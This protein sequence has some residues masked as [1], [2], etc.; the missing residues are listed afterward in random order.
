MHL[1]KKF[2]SA[3]EYLARL[4]GKVPS[5]YKPSPKGMREVTVFTNVWIDPI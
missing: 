4:I 5:L 3:L 1:Q 2:E